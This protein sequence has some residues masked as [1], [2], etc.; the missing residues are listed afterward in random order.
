MLMIKMGVYLIGLA[1]FAGA[2]WA[3]GTW[4]PEVSRGWGGVAFL[5]V[6]VLMYYPICASA[7]IDILGHEINECVNAEPFN[8][9]RYNKL[10]RAIDKA[11]GQ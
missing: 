9:K 11:M 2:A 1:F 8:E 3:F 10:K 6:G 7:Y 5:V 4:F